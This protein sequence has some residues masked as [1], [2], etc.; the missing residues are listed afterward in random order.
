MKRKSNM[1]SLFAV[2]ALLSSVFAMSDA[3]AFTQSGGPDAT[4]I[5]HEWLTV[6]GA[7]ATGGTALNP[8]ENEV[9]GK[10][11][12]CGAGCDQY[13]T[14]SLKVWS[15]VMGQRWVDI[16]GFLVL[17]KLQEKQWWDSVAQNVDRVQ[18][19]HFLRKST[20]K[21]DKGAVK[22]IN[23]S[24]ARF[25]KYFIDAANENSDMIPFTDGG[26]ARSHR[27]AI[28]AYFFF[29]RAVHLFQ[30]SFSP[31]HS[32]R[33][34][35]DGYKT[36]L[37]IKSY[38]CTEDSPQHGHAFPLFWTYKT[39]GDII[40]KEMSAKQP[41]E[42]A[43]EFSNLKP[44]AAAAH[45]ATKD[46]WVAFELSRANPGTAGSE[47]DKIIAKWMKYKPG[48]PASKNYVACEKEPPKSQEVLENERDATLTAICAKYPGQ[49][50][51]GQDGFNDLVPP[52]RW[53]SLPPLSVLAPPEKLM[54]ARPIDAPISADFLPKAKPAP[55]A[56]K[57]TVKKVKAPRI[58]KGGKKNIFEGEIVDRHGKLANVKLDRGGA[59]WALLS[60][61]QPPE[62]YSGSEP[63]TIGG[64][65]LNPFRVGDPIDCGSA[66]KD[67]TCMVTEV[68][69]Y[70]IKIESEVG[71]IR[72][73]VA[74]D[75]TSLLTDSN[76]DN[77]RK[78]L[79]AKTGADEMT[80]AKFCYKN[81]A[82]HGVTE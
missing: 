7:K 21:G 42:F 30:D 24:I 32:S 59:V 62:Q 3:R 60:E 6:A 72:W 44:E 61:I 35:T 65:R 4:P 40:W 73:R 77:Y 64:V 70:L 39:N 57:P 13:D 2:A 71:Q 74:R 49:T 15:A 31:E 16:M 66:K 50:C 18:Y 63:G 22:A 33:D 1:N 34:S 25:R 26:V 58:D 20:E 45:D 68:Y 36:I 41:G 48:S 69:G 52:F 51:A 19:D 78:C 55:V 17:P 79:D 75:S 43:L 53:P 27:K 10:S 37:D 54:T 23:E 14:K 82:S 81:R 67:R 56:P 8:S 29:G 38:L 80:K 47:V 5:G 46:L 9:T 11:A 28:R 76:R 12:D